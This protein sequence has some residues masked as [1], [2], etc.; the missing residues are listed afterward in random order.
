[1]RA[2]HATLVLPL[3]LAAFAAVRSVERSPAQAGVGPPSDSAATVA[4]MRRAAHRF[5]TTEPR[6]Y[7]AIV[8]ADSTHAT[9]P[10]HPDR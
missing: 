2:T 1:M 7:D 6:E 3:V 5:E 4:W 8:L 10:N 9:Q